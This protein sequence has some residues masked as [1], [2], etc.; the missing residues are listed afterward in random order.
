[1]PKVKISISL[2][3]SVLHA[4]DQ[5]AAIGGESRTA[6]IERWLRDASRRAKAKRLDEETAAYY[7]S[8][9]VSEQEENA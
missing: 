8:L 9:S 6:V 2:D 5:S 4:V 1:M 3:P 7:E